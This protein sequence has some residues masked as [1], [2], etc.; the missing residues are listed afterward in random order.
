MKIAKKTPAATISAA[1]VA[2]RNWTKAHP[3]YWRQL[4]AKRKAAGQCLVCQQPS[5]TLYCQ[6]CRDRRA[7]L[8]Q[9]YRLRPDVKLKRA[10]RAAVSHAIKRGRLIKP[11]A[12]QLCGKV[13]RLEAHHH[14]YAERLNVRWL[15]SV[16]HG[17]EHKVIS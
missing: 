6:D 13:G 15:C 10:V 4:A 14:N 8:Q 9:Q 16:C 3:Q 12:C 11:K 7:L 1:A 17:I 5:A 2:Q